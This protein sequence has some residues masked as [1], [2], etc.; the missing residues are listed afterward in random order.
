M[1]VSALFVRWDSV[2]F[3]LCDAWDA[4]R[5]AVEYCGP[6]PVVAHPPCRGWGRFASR[7]SASAWERQ[8]AVCAVQLVREFGGVLEHPAASG[9]WGHCGLPRPGAK[10]DKFG[11]WSL[12]VDQGWFGHPCPKPTWLYVVGR[13]PFGHD[14]CPVSLRRA[15]GRVEGQTRADRERTSPGFARWLLSVA[16][17]CVVDAAPATSAP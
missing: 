17:G 4:T 11:G 15:P 8:L 9:L 3:D 10:V 6:W 7:S 12:F 2:Y 14:A 16:Q 1:S 5:D 13:A